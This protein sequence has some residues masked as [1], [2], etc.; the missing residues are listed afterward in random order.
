MSEFTT[1][2]GNVQAK[3]LKLIAINIS[4]QPRAMPKKLFHHNV[5]VYTPREK[6]HSKINR[7]LN[8]M[9]ILHI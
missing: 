7:F 6:V 4:G 9:F 1:L 2:H 5:L 3:L 8:K